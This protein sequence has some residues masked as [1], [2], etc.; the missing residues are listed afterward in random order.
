MKPGIARESSIQRGHRAEVN[1]L[2]W[3]GL[4][5]SF[6]CLLIPKANGPTGSPYLSSLSKCMVGCPGRELARTRPEVAVLS[7]TAPVSCAGRRG[8]GIAS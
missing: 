8:S 3:E 2:N 4:D 1:A 7:F 6:Q 5:K